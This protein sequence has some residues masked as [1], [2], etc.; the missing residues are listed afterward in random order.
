[1]YAVSRSVEDIYTET[2]IHV[3]VLFVYSGIHAS[4]I[5]QLAFGIHVAM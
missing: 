4:Q 1:M 5:D 3:C 2:H